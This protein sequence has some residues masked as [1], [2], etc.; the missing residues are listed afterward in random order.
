MKY[1]FSLV[2]ALLIVLLVISAITEE[3]VLDAEAIATRVEG[4]ITLFTKEAPAGRLIREHDS[5]AANDRLEVQ[6]NSRIELRFPDG[7]YVRLSESAHFTVRL[8]QFEKQTDSLYAQVFLGAGKL[9]A[10][11]KKLPASHSRVEV[12][13]TAGSAVAASAVYSVAVEEGPSATVSVYEGAVQAMGAA[14]DLPRTADQTGAPAE[15]RPVSVAA[16]QQV[17]LSAQGSVS[18]PMNFDPKAAINDWIRWNLRLDA[19]EGLVS[20]TTTPDQSTITNGQS[21]QFTGTANYPD[22]SSKD[23]TWFAAWTSSDD[24]VA[25]VD[26]KGA[27]TGAELGTAR[28]SAALIDMSGSAMLTVIRELVSISVKPVSRSIMNGSVQQFKAMAIFSDKTAADITS[29]VAWKSSNTGVAVI[30]ANGRATAGNTTGTAV[31]SASLGKKTGSTSL[32]VRRELLSITVTP[33]GAT[34][35]EGQTQRFEAIGVY[36][37]KTT[38]NLTTTVKWKISDGKIAGITQAGLVT[39]KTG[40]GTAVLSASLGGKAGSGNI[41][42]TRISLVSLTVQPAEATI[43]QMMS[44]QFIARGSFSDG[45]T[46]DLTNSVSWTS[47]APLLAPIKATGLASGVL[48]GSSSITAMSQGNSA[49]A[50]LKVTEREV[51][52]PRIDKET[53]KNYVFWP[54]SRFTRGAGPQLGHGAVVSDRV[55]GLTWTEDAATPGPTACRPGLTKTWGAALD[56]IACLN[57]SIYLGYHNW[58]L[59]NKA[60]LSGLLDYQQQAPN[61]LVYTQGFTYVQVFYCD[62]FWLDGKGND[63]PTYLDMGQGTVHRTGGAIPFHVWPV[64]SEQ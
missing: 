22:N 45:S 32:K 5:I 18:P 58:R 13:A 44:Q 10:K 7:S 42:V 16:L 46:Q 35:Q 9:W 1:I 47:S 41:T 61:P 63:V 23:I 4:N 12:V 37:D 57:N 11:L 56:Y 29:S 3:V 14:R 54:V 48:P 15:G 38:K 21:L 52:R 60:E 24:K 43:R 33:G 40:G 27:A 26:Q 64:R 19:R 25:V 62:E 30:D 59:P 36:S 51:C 53:A 39:G 55:T 6:P 2:V 8:L 50:M 28:I 20:I 17:S 34:I 31:I 49:S